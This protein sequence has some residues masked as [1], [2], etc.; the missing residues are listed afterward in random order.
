MAETVLARL[1]ALKTAPIGDLKQQWRD[2]FETEPPVFN[3]RYLESRLA[4][5]IGVP[6][7]IDALRHPDGF[8]G[9]LVAP[10]AHFDRGSGL[11]G[12]VAAAFGL[13]VPTGGL[14]CRPELGEPNA[15]TL[16]SET[17]A[18]F[19]ISVSSGNLCFVPFQTSGIKRRS[20][21]PWRISVEEKDRAA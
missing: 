12:I 4:Y 19:R 3:R 11:V 1:A 21:E 15:L 2:L 6:A 18:N 13:V 16:A 5:R 8:A 14:R 7:G 17:D 9:A 10:G 20:P